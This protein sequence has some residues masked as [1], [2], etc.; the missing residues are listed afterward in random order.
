MLTKKYC[1]MTI[2][3]SKETITPVNNDD[4]RFDDEITEKITAYHLEMIHMFAKNGGRVA[5]GSD[6]GAWA[7]PHGSETEPELLARADITTE[8]YW[9]GNRVIMEKFRRK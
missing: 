7:V 6:A 2:K 5:L 3:E 4:G 8:R 9:Q 1:K